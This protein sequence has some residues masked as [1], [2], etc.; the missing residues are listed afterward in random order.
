VRAHTLERLAAAGVP[1]APCL[2]FEE[3][4]ADEHLQANGCFAE[5]EDPT[6]GRVV[7]GGPLLH[8]EAT[9]IGPART[10]PQLGADGAQVLRELGYGEERIVALREARVVGP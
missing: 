2:T 5:T 3:L 6:L 1:A 9:P 8:F 4:W 10:A 7:Q